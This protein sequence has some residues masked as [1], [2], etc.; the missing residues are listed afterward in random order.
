MPD[1]VMSGCRLRIGADA[2]EASKMVVC[3]D[4]EDSLS[5]SDPGVGP[6]DDAEVV[7]HL[8]ET[9]PG[10]FLQTSRPSVSS[11]ANKADGCFDWLARDFLGERLSC[12]SS[13]IS[14][15]TCRSTTGT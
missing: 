2:A 6:V 11:V 5:L 15:S 7:E 4:C 10:R 12:N 14:E 9:L 13:A 1:L 8:E 3:G